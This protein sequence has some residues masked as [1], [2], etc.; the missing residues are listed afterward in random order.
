M[1]RR[2]VGV[3]VLAATTAISA[4]ASGGDPD[5]W[6]SRDKALHFDVSAGIAAAG[7]G[8]SAAW[9]V[10]ARWQALVLGGGLALAV[11]AGKEIVDATG[12]FGADPSWKDLAWDAIGAIAGLAIAWSVDLWLGGVDEAHPALGSPPT[13][14]PAKPASALLRF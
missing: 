3:V 13:A 5:P 10:D 2:L 1:M 12:L 4:R 8:A 7:Y 14:A 6:L 9:L 11:G